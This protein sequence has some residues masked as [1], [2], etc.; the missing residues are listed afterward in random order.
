MK[1][2]EFKGLKQG[3]EPIPA[4]DSDSNEVLKERRIRIMFYKMS[5]KKIRPVLTNNEIKMIDTGCEFLTLGFFNN[6]LGPDGLRLYSLTHFIGRVWPRN[7]STLT[8]DR[9][10][11]LVFNEEEAIARFK[12]ANWMDCRIS[13][14]PSFTEYKGINRQAPNFIFYGPR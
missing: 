1:T 4:S 13:A 2:D 3:F 14:Y 11:I 8:T 9:R 6:V 7:I 12:Q 10:Q 5:V